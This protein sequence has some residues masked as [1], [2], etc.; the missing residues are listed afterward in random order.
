MAVVC[1]DIV[2]QRLVLCLPFATVIFVACILFLH[3]VC[4]IM[5]APGATIT[6]GN[7][8]IMITACDKL[9]GYSVMFYRIVPYRITQA[10][11]VY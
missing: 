11:V 6:N 5:F 4:R 7:V 9:R 1:D 2:V 3:F 10:R 8:T